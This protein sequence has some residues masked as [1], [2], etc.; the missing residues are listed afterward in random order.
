MHSIGLPSNKSEGIYF[1][2]FF[3]FSHPFFVKWEKNV[4]PASLKYSGASLFFY[5]PYESLVRPIKERAWGLESL[6]RVFSAEV[7]AYI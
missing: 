7:Q 6:G 4:T 1:F 2:S 5:L 3:L